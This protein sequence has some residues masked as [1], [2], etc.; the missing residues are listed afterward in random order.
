MLYRL[1]TYILRVGRNDD[2]VEA[3]LVGLTCYSDCQGKGYIPII[4]IAFFSHRG[5]PISE[6][7]CFLFLH[8]NALICDTLVI[9][10]PAKLSTVFV[11]HS[12]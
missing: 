10:I 9:L 3:E 1:D 5:A 7:C 8:T 12:C 2:P 6:H 4:S 11:Q